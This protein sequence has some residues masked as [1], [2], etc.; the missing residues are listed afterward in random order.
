MKSRTLIAVLA[1]LSMVVAACDD[2]AVELSTTSS[3]ISGTT[4]PPASETTTTTSSDETGSTST[5]LRGENVSSFDQVARLSDENGETLVIVIPPG[6]YT[7]VDLENFIGELRESNPELW[8]AEVFDDVAA[9]EAFQV[10]EG[11]RT[12][13]Q[14]VLLDDHHFISLSGDTV[15]FQGPFAEFGEYIIGS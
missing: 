2:G 4:E 1:M 15:R 5:T 3:L 10:A 11:D 14:Q 7:D 8:G 12:A 13:D 9:A 6:A